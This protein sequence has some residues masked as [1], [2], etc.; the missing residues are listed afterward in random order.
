MNEVLLSE[1]LGE[2]TTTQV[3]RD[4]EGDY[5]VRVMA[6]PADGGEALPASASP[7]IFQDNPVSEAEARA[8]YGVSA[9]KRYVEADEAFAAPGPGAA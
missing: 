5:R 7:R 6:L 3:Y 4:A 2:D 9:A 1:T 8:L